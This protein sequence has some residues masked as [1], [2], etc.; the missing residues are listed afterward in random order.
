MTGSY[1]NPR[2]A[3]EKAKGAVRAQDLQFEKCWVHKTVIGFGC[4]LWSYFSPISEAPVGTVWFTATWDKATKR[5]RAEIL[6]IYVPQWARR[7]GIATRLVEALREEYDVLL[8]TIG[9]RSGA[10]FMRATGWRHRPKECM[11][12]RTRK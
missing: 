6:D 8:T 11:W 12:I 5:S 7:C 3:A 4:R 9:T 10:P 2:P 1:P